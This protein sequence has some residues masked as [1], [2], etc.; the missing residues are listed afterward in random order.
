[1]GTQRKMR[2]SPS[3]QPLTTPYA[4]IASTAYCEQVGMYIHASGKRGEMHRWY[5]RMA[6]MAVRLNTPFT[7]ILGPGRVHV[8]AVEQRLQ[9]SLHILGRRRARARGS[10]QDNLTTLDR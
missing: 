7:T 5:Q 2:R 3:Q 6:A 4:C 9:C 8:R 1:M 10:E